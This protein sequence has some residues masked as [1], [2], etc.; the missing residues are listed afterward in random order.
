MTGNEEAIRV[1]RLLAA[2][3][4]E[5]FDALTDAGRMAAWFSP[6]GRAEV[7]ADA[8]V[9][10]RLR[11]VMIDGDVRLEHDGEFL[12]V[13][14]PTRLSFTWR[15]RFTDG[16]PTVVTVE[17]SDEDGKTRLVLHHDRLPPEERA[18]HAGGW[19]AILDRLS[20]VVATSA[21]GRYSACS[22]T[23]GPRR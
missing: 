23:S 4:E 15:S 7:E 13:R 11:V 22:S 18:S 3:I 8:I 2:P 12:D 20:A 6:V 5:V 19:G 21:G 1:E 10:G 16:R 17:L 9:G 14:R